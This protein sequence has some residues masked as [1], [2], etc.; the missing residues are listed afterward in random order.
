MSKQYTLAEIDNPSTFFSPDHH[1]DPHPE[2]DLMYD[3][4][5][6]SYEDNNNN[7]TIQFN[8]SSENNNYDGEDDEYSTVMAHQNDPHIINEEQLLPLDEPQDNNYSN[9]HDHAN[10]GRFNPP[11]H[12]SNYTSSIT[13]FYRGSYSYC[14]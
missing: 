14:F 7:N 9:S 5:N 13:I 11:N 4:H 12:I 6:I 10:N 1:H 3:F 8:P 2:D